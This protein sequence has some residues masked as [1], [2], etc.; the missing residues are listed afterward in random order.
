M[1][2]CFVVLFYRLPVELQLA[3]VMSGSREGALAQ[4]LFGIV[5]AVLADGQYGT[6]ILGLGAIACFRE[7]TLG[8]C[9][10]VLAKGDDGGVEVGRLVVGIHSDSGLKD[11]VIVLRARLVGVGHEEHLVEAQVLRLLTDDAGGLL[12]A[13]AVADL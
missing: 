2:Y 1:C 13:H 10:V 5:E 6:G 12:A 9:L 4:H 7:I 8:S 11:V 3:Q